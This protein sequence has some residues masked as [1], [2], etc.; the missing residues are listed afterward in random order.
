MTE[1]HIASVSCARCG[2]RVSVHNGIVARNREG[3]VF[4]VDSIENI[5]RESGL[6]FCAVCL[7][8]VGKSLTNNQVTLYWQS[9]RVN[10]LV[11]LN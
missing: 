8:P 2:I 4:N 5:H 11:R 10:S 7:R 3:L 6:I 1:T 9:V